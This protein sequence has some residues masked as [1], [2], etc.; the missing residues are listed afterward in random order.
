MLTLI[1]SRGLTFIEGRLYVEL[2]AHTVP[3]HHHLIEGL[4]LGRYIYM[5]LAGALQN[6]VPCHLPCA[7]I[8]EACKCRLQWHLITDFREGF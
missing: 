4:S 1:H 7:H 2:C 8:P 6:K 5:T 3:P